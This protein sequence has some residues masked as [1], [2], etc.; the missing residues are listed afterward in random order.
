M[1]FFTIMYII[2]VL[3]NIPFFFIFI[4][5]KIKKSEAYE[6]TTEGWQTTDIVF[7]ISMILLSFFSFCLFLLDQCGRLL[8]NRLRI[9]INT[10]S[11]KRD[12][13]KATNKI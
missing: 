1:S 4:D 5:D 11:T 13:S 3:V 12:L 10:I 7:Y 6:Y 8:F 2:F 9:L